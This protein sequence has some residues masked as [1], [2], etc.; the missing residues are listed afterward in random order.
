MGRCERMFRAV[1]VVLALAFTLVTSLPLHAQ[2]VLFG[3]TQ[4]T[5]TAGPP[6]QFTATFMRCSAGTTAPYTIHIVNGHADGTKRISS[7]TIKVN[8]LQVAGPERFR[9]KRRGDRPD[10]RPCTPNEYPRESASPARPAACSR[11]ACL[12]YRCRISAH[13]PST[14]NP[15]N[16]L[17]GRHDRHRLD[18]HLSA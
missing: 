1:G 17:A 16:L 9:A 4:Y 6:N 5:R 3:P 15:L 8:G 18:R 7:A 14:P 2:T 10:R 12:G 11:S 13:R